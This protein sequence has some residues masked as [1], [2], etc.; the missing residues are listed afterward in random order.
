MNKELE[1]V[2]RETSIIE[3]GRQAAISG[4]PM[5]DNPYTKGDWNG[6]NQRAADLWFDGWMLGKHSLTEDEQREQFFK[7]HGCD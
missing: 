3:S 1:R 4:R 5:Q 6:R 2:S 7:N